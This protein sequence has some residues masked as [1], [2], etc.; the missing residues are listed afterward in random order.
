[1]NLFVVMDKTIL[2]KGVFG[3]FFTYESA[4][5][6]AKI[7]EEKTGNLCEVKTLPVTGRF[8]DQTYIFAAHS[9]DVLHDSYIVDGLYAEL[10]DAQE[11][12]GQKG[13]IVKTFIDVPDQNQYITL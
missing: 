5:S 13:L 3:V 12:V 7:F 11:A 1:M 6:F 10:L 9:Y 4:M 8:D 2:G